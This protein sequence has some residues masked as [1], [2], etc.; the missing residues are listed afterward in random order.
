MISVIFVVI[1]I[2]CT[3]NM[4]FIIIIEIIFIGFVNG[5][6]CYDREPRW[7]SYCSPFCMQ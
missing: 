2:G 7:L 4:I 1:V 6:N 5:E 3:G